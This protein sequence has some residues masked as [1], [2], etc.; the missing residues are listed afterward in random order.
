VNP[1]GRTAC[2]LLLAA[3]AAAAQPPK[4]G[5]IEGV[6]TNA[7]TG[8]PV[9]RAHVMLR[10]DKKRYGAMSTAEGKFSIATVEPG[11]YALKTER[12]GFVP[13]EA[14]VEIRPE[15]T[16]RAYNAELTPEGSIA[17]KVVKPDGEP[18]EGVKVEASKTGFAL[19]RYTNDRGEFRLDGLPPGRYRLTA[20]PSRTVLPPDVRTDGTLE[21]YFGDLTHPGRLAVGPGAELTA[22]EMRL[23]RT[24]SIR[25]SGVLTGAAGPQVQVQAERLGD[26]DFTRPGVV[27]GSAFEIWN[28]TPG[29]YRIGARVGMLTSA[30]EEVEVVATN[31][32]G[33]ELRVMAPFEIAGRVEWSGPPLA[34]LAL[35][36]ASP[37][38]RSVV[39]NVRPD[40]SFQAANVGPERYEILTPGAFAKSVELG[41]TP[42]RG[43]I[44]DLSRG[45][46]APIAIRLSAEFASVTGTVRDTKDP[47]TVTLEPEGRPDRAQRVEATGS[48]S[49]TSVVPGV[50]RLY[51]SED[52]AETI[53]LRANDR[54]LRDVRV[55]R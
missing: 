16:V 37:R 9:A 3:F 40:G 52:D 7:L 46:G 15:M 38:R 48:Y 11:V 30:T 2:V 22:I 6:V 45:A 29:K 33:I 5:A 1:L 47:V 24:R 55:K 27:K 49:F 28:L 18:M 39:A 36:P 19:H 20:A 53:E 51:I 32:E 10:A 12:A 14:R 44:L 8:E 42:M 26:R 4:P 34:Q 50:Y 35:I 31:I 13:L 25:V 43:G 17:G 41:P 54:L 21:E 23:Q